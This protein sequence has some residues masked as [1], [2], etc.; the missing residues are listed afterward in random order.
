MN[1][2]D[3]INILAESQ[4]KSIKL[5]KEIIDYVKEQTSIIK[6]L[7][8]L[9]SKLEK[10]I[11]KLENKINPPNLANPYELKYDEHRFKK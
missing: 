10:R 4:I 5:E 1:I 8:E 2:Q 6:D 7:I 11:E 3:K 9:V